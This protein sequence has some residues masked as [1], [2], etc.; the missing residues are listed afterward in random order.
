MHN[1]ADILIAEPISRPNKT[2]KV[3]SFTYLCIVRQQINMTVSFKSVCAG[4]IS[5]CAHTWYAASVI[6]THSSIRGTGL[7]SSSTQ[8]S[9]LIRR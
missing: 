6:S 8:S 4:H 5:V 1:W 3:R 2:S 9:G 7:V